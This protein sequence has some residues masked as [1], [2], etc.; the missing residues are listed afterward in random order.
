MSIRFYK[1]LL[2]GASDDTFD[3]HVDISSSEPCFAKRSDASGQTVTLHLETHPMGRKELQFQH[4]KLEP[5]SI[6][7]IQL[8]LPGHNP[9]P[10]PRAQ[11]RSRILRYPPFS[12]SLIG[13]SVEWE[14]GSEPIL[15][16]HSMNHCVFQLEHV[17]S[18]PVYVIANVPAGAQSISKTISVAEIEEG[19]L[20]IEE[21]ANW[22]DAVRNDEAFLFKIEH[23][24][25]KNP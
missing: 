17:D 7:E 16:A 5:L 2:T 20:V 13:V 15:R 8:S 6:Y 23:Q 11:I 10:Q 4:L 12:P 25:H 9:P 3:L 22:E 21:E 14:E 24:N 1:I 18:I 19:V